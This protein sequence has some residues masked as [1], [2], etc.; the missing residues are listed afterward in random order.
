MDSEYQNSWLVSKFSLNQIY[1]W[2]TRMQEHSYLLASSHLCWVWAHPKLKHYA[3]LRHIFSTRAIV[4]SVSSHFNWIRWMSI[5]NVMWNLCYLLLLFRF[6]CIF[7]RCCMLPVFR[8]RLDQ[9]EDRTVICTTSDYAKHHASLTD[10]RYIH[11][12]LDLRKIF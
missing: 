12:P 8:G 11:K 2:Q 1:F 4:K 7:G 10:F 6:V 9:F 3:D 5:T